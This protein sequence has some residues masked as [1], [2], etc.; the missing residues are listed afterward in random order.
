MASCLVPWWGKLLICSWGSKGYCY[1]ITNSFM[2]SIHQSSVDDSLMLMS[3][4]HAVRVY[5][6]HYSRRTL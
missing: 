6:S 4:Y 1:V 3:S 5:R 2:V